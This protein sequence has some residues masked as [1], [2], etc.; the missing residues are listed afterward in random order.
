MQ[1]PSRCF[2]IA[3]V[4]SKFNQDITDKLYQGAIQ[5]LKELEFDTKNIKTVFVPGA[6][7]IPLAAQ[8]LAKTK[9]YAAIVT[10]GSVVMGETKHFDYVCQLA[11]N[12]CQAVSLQFDIPVIFG[13]LTTNTQEQAYARAG[14]KK[15]NVGRSS[16]D[17]AI[18]L[19]EALE[20]I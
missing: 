12:G 5:R 20:N 16:I 17:T 10:L 8:R 13:V 9:Q 6:V 14:G 4:V 2:K 15:C 7:E 19:I 1:K 3:I 11:S 18:D